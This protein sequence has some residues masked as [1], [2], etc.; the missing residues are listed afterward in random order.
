MCKLM[1]LVLIFA[2]RWWCW[3]GDDMSTA[4][5]Q[6]S[7]LTSADGVTQLTNVKKMKEKKKKKE[8]GVFGRFRPK[9]GY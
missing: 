7:A 4:I 3:C 5:G 9:S 8:V 6:H 1:V 2:C